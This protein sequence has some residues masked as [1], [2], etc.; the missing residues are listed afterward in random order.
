MKR[1]FLILMFLI[2]TVFAFSGPGFFISFFPVLSLN[3]LPA[4]DRDYR[5][6]MYDMYDYFTY[7]AFATF[8]IELSGPSYRALLRFDFRQDLSAYLRGKGWSNLPQELS[9]YRHRSAQGRTGRI[10]ELPDQTFGRQEEAPLRAGHVQLRV[11]GNRSLLRTSV[12]R[13]EHRGLLRQ[14]FL[15]LFPH[16]FR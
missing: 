15:Q 5:P 11:V 7:P 8:G 4:H 16:L 2:V 14:I 3:N 6:T 12:V 1:L 9:L 13:F 10:R